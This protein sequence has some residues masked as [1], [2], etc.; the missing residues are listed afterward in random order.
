MS[1]RLQ[2]ASNGWGLPITLLILSPFIIYNFWRK[3][4]SK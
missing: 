1:P 4:R 3:N 2:R